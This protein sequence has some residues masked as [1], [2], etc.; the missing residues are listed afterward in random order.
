MAE[1]AGYPLKLL[2]VEDEGNTRGLI[3]MGVN[4]TALGVRVVGEAATGAEALDLMETLAPDI[5]LTDIEMPHMNGLAL[6]RRVM[7][8]CPD[9]LVVILTAHDHFAYAQEAVEA[10]VARYILK[11]VDPERIEPAMWEIVQRIHERRRLLSRDSSREVAAQTQP[12]DGRQLAELIMKGSHEEFNEQLAEF[13]LRFNPDSAYAIALFSLSG[14]RLEPPLG[15]LSNVRAYVQ[16]NFTAGGRLF[17]FEDGLDK[18][19]LLCEHDKVDL[20][21]L[22]GRIMDAVAETTKVQLCCGVSDP[23]RDLARLPSAYAQA[24]D[25]LRLAMISQD[26]STE[27]ADP[28][29]RGHARERLK[30]LLLFI[31]SGLS[32]R[33]LAMAQ[34][35]FK[36]AADSYNGDRNAVK[37]FVMDAVARAMDTLA[38][39]EIPWLT[40]TE[41]VTPFFI[42][43]LSAETLEALSEQF[44]TQVEQLC[45]LTEQRH[46]QRASET[47]ARVMRDLEVN[48]QDPEQ[49]LT[50]LARKY[51]LNS[52][53]LSRAFKAYTGK[54]FSEYLLELRIQKACDALKHGDCKAYQLAQMVG[55]P[56]PSYFAKCFK[57][58]TGVS[59][60]AYKAQGERGLHA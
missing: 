42:N 11:P 3:R 8:R 51:S 37:L 15:L 44:N 45:R 57:K 48:Y 58:V 20:L 1:T 6:S 9:V 35:L 27:T 10:G 49:S 23:V 21:C 50:A 55:I 26:D 56:D 19:A 16:E 28:D 24:L 41:L 14:G 31:K 33:S 43:A 5:V 59:F 40:L 46:Q 18:L 53:Y 7:E 17:A 32:Q 25:A 34:T 38:G 22:C 4:W 36:Q 2:V 60:Q 12:R 30:D 47:V 52:S 13:G 39:Q 54:A 29:T